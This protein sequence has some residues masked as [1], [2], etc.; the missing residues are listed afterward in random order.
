MV[1]TPCATRGEVAAMAL[2]RVGADTS[3]SGST[4]GVPVMKQVKGTP[5]LSTW[6]IGMQHRKVSPWVI[7]SESEER[8]C[9]ASK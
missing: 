2:A 5:Q 7:H 3:A 4:S 9:M 8:S 6:Q 1:G